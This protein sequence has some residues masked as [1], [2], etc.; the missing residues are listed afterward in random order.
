M[1]K[2]VRNN[3]VNLVSEEAGKKVEPHEA[4]LRKMTGWEYNYALQLKMHEEWRE[5]WEDPCPE[6]FADCLEVLQ[7]A[8]AYHG[9]DWNDVLEARAKKFAEKGSFD[10]RWEMTIK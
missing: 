9:V 10:H 7:A 1:R 6:E 8:A 2:L 3:I 4:G 5:A